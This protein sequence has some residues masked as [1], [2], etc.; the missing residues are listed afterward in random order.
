MPPHVLHSI[1][2]ILAL[3]GFVIFAA[4]WFRPCLEWLVRHVPKPILSFY[5]LYCLFEVISHFGWTHVGLLDLCVP[6][7]ILGCC[8]DV[9]EILQRR[10]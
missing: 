6:L 10:K 5:L 1:L 2:L 3:P 8:A 9:Y 7:A 4:M